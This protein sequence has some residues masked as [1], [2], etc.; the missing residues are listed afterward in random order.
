M[1]S[2]G[3]AQYWD[4]G[5]ESRMA[6][7]QNCSKQGLLSARRVGSRIDFRVEKRAQKR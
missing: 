1:D 4:F 2:G 5:M 7:A 3:F 6:G